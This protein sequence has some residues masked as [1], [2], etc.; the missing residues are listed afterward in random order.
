MVGRW[1]VGDIGV[2]GGVNNGVA[3]A[4]QIKIL[5]KFQTKKYQDTVLHTST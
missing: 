1:E 5:R 3:K 4:K 2:H